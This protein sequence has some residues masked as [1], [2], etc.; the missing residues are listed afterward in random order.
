MLRLIILGISVLT[1]ISGL[2]QMIQ[3]DFVLDFVGGESTPVTRHFFGTIGMF[4]LILGGLMVQALYE[5]QVS[6]AALFWGGLQK[7]GAAIA[8]GIGI[9]HGLM[10]PIAGLVASFDFVSGI[11]FFVYLRSLKD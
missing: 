7:F 10:S 2:V 6:R 1:F 4:M 8:V 3:P 5:A 11:L 9:M